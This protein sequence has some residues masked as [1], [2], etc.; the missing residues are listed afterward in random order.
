[1]TTLAADYSFA[2]PE[3][4]AFKQ[5]GYDVVLRYLSHTDEKNLTHPE[6]KALRHA[7]LS[8]GL[9]W[10]TT[11]DRALAGNPAGDQDRIDAEAMAAA[12]GY[13]KT[14][15]IFYAV[16]TDVAPDAVD[17]YFANVAK[18][19][20]HPVGVYGSLRVCEGMRAAGHVTYLWQTE[21]WSGTDVSKH[22]HI[23]QRV[24]ATKNLPKGCDED[25]LLKPL[26]LWAPHSDQPVDPTPG[27][28]DDKAKPIGEMPRIAARVVLKEL[29]GRTAPIATADRALLADLRAAINDAMRLG[30]DALHNGEASMV[31]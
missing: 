16:D 12:L 28:A 26:P 7:G 10:E 25:V 13:P 11:A 15:V 22:A 9:V 14:C 18:G 31:R 5:A 6:A 24:K 29:R 2:H 30:A 27:P 1:V 8:V 19:A 17:E 3:P 23:Y 20:T 4:T 21:A